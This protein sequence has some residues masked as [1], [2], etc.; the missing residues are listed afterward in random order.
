MKRTK[1]NDKP[2]DIT[3][4]CPLAEDIDGFDSPAFLEKLKSGIFD[5]EDIKN[6]HGGPPKLFKNDFMRQV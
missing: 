3:S 6:P 4:A 5:K 1:I 2:K